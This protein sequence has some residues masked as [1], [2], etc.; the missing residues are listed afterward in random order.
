MTTFIVDRTD[1]EPVTV[2]A[3]RMEIGETTG[4]L[5]FWKDGPPPS[6]PEGELMIMSLRL[7]A[8]YPNGFWRSVRE[9]PDKP[10]DTKADE[11]K[12]W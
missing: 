1:C 2:D 11:R 7:I 6:G 3:H 4:L 12:T 9:L 10:D 8:A 5:T